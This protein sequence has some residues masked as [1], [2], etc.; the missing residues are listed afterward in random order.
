VTVQHDGAGGARPAHATQVRIATD[1]DPESPYTLVPSN[2]TLPFALVAPSAWKTQDDVSRLD[3]QARDGHA[4]ILGWT[5]SYLK[6]NGRLPTD[7]TK[8][9]LV[10]QRGLAPWPGNPYDGTDMR[11]QVASGHFQWL[12]CSDQDAVFHGFGWDGAP[13]SRTFGTGCTRSGQPT[14]VSSGFSIHPE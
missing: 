3:A 12:R 8:D 6:Q 4:A 10:L 13:L 5:E 9:S 1:L 7:L 14:S 2:A 11:N